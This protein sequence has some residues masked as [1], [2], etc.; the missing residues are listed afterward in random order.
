MSETITFPA[1]KRTA[2]LVCEGG[3][4]GLLQFG[5]EQNIDAVLCLRQTELG[6]AMGESERLP[7]A[8]GQ[9][10]RFQP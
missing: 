8:D 9:Q 3:Q 10:R 5:R 6:V 1:S 2:L 4:V 7:D